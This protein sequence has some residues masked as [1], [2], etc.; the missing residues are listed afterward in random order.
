MA[1][2]NDLIERGYFP[3]E[4]PPLFSTIELGK[5]VSEPVN[6]NGTLYGIN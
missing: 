5:A 2:A 3:K 4:L 6:D 1:I